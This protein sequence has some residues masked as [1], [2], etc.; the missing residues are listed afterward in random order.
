MPHIPHIF[1]ITISKSHALRRPSDARWLWDVSTGYITFAFRS[2][3]ELLYPPWDAKE[4]SHQFYAIGW[5]S[6]PLILGTGVVMGVVLAEFI[7]T[8]LGNLVPVES[9]IPAELSR[10]MFREMGPLMTGLL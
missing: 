10:M 2:L 3:R 7:W 9:V 5:R 1:H 8:S 6:T 4:I